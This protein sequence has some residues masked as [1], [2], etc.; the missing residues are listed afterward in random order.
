M[1][2]FVQS[3]PDGQYY[4]DLDA[5]LQAHKAESMFNVIDLST[6]WKIDFII[7]KSRP[8][9]REEF[10]RR[11]RVDLQGVFPFLASAEDILIAKLEWSK[12]ARSQ[13]QIEDAVSILRA[14]GQTLDRSYIGRRASELR[15]EAEWSIV[16]DRARI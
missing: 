1:R 5:A 9:S 16:Q 14:R 13:R 3:L 11:V 6:G 15:L 12:L 4:A 8:F 7:R 2:G 10:S